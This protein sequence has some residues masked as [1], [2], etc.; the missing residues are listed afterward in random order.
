MIAPALAGLDAGFIRQQSEASL[1]SALEW[2]LPRC[3]DGA[4]RS[5]FLPLVAL[6]GSL[7]ATVLPVSRPDGPAV[8]LRVTFTRIGPDGRPH[9]VRFALS[10]EPQAAESAGDEERASLEN[11]ELHALALDELACIENPWETAGAVV[12]KMLQL[13][14]ARGS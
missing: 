6:L 9:R 5:M 4:N 1:R 11:G 13:L 10:S 3:G 14:A 8:D 12:G 2:G 7:N